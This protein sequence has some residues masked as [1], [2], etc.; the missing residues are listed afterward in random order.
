MKYAQLFQVITINNQS[1][2]VSRYIVSER[3]QITSIEQQNPDCSV[4]YK[5]VK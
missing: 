4:S 5:K 3:W 2:E 1:G